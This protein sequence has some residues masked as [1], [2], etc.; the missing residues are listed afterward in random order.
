MGIKK[1]QVKKNVFT[2]AYKCAVNGGHNTAKWLIQK[3][4]NVNGNERVMELL[5]HRCHNGKP[6]TIIDILDQ[7]LDID[8]HVKN[9][10]LFIR[11]EK[12][13]ELMNFMVDK[14]MYD[15]TRYIFR[16]NTKYVVNPV[17][18]IKNYIKTTINSCDIYSDG[19]PDMDMLHEYMN[20]IKQPKSARNIIE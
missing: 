6:K 14:V 1:H 3:T 12:D 15:T 11:L 7:F 8:V 13:D 5:L 16:A 9:E 10:F 17:D 2:K 18:P 20:T 19:E 4:F